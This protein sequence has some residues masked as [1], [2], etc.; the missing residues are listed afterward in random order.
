MRVIATGGL[1]PLFARGTKIIEAADGD[2]TMR[3]L[4]LIHRYNKTGKYTG[5]YDE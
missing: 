5:K 1:S 2:L 4:V 3:G